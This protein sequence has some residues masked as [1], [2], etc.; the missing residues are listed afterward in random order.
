M[1]IK[2]TRAIEAKGS[3]GKLKTTY[4]LGE[5]VEVDDAVGDAYIAKGYAA[6][7]ADPE[8]T[9]GALDA[10][11]K[12]EIDGVKASVAELLRSVREQFTAAG[13]AMRPAVG[14]EATESED[15]KFSQTGG[16]RSFGHFA[17]TIFR[18][19]LPNSPDSECGAALVKYRDCL[20]RITRAPSGMYEASDPDGALLIP[21]TFDQ[22][23]WERVRNYNSIIDDITMIPIGGNTWQ[24]PADA[25]TS[26]VDGQR[27]GGIQGFWEGEASQYTKSKPTF[28]DRYLRLKKVT[29]LVFVTNE[30]LE[31]APALEGY[32]NRV[33][34]EE[35]R[36]KLNDGLVNGTGAGMPMGLLTSKS[37]V[38]IAKD[39]SQTA[40]TVS[41][42]NL[43]N[44]WARLY[45]PCRANANW[46]INQDVEPQIQMAALP[47]GQYSGQLI[48]TPP[49]GISGS[50]YGTLYGRP[51]IPI[52]QCQTRGTE[53]DVILADPTQVLGIRKQAGLTQSMSIHLRFDYDETC[54]KFL[55][56]MDAQ[57]AWEKPLT[58]FK[59]SNTQGAIVTIA[60][61]S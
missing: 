56:R 2:L 52:E 7:A 43:I 4:A 26:R 36:F 3:D 28:S 29:V 55:L 30:Q 9:E 48:Y 13:K 16:F 35:I 12:A 24:M 42:M 44:A 37:R 32:L 5:I 50:P 20:G 21:P 34:P 10:A 46:Y 61:R 60:V 11:T 17:S 6:R 27:R 8:A 40:A 23:I 33:A 19:N 39:T 49:G 31:D 51:V 18:G 1:W 15:E 58:P 57:P 47:T 53:G 22:R 25:E 45:A 14:V 54:F 41:G 38:T 59:G